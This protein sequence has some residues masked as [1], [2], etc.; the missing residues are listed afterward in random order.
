MYTRQRKSRIV[1]DSACPA[2]REKGRDKTG[3]HLIHFEDGSKHCNRCGYTVTNNRHLSTT[4]EELE[5]SMDYHQL[6][7]ADIPDRKIK[8]SVVERYGVK[9]G[10]SPENGEPMFHL[11]PVTKDGAVS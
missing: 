6:S 10:M 4:D 3:N 9:V 2:C 1:G 8:K 7:S 5:P 11:Y